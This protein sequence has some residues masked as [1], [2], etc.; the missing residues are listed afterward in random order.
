[1]ASIRVFLR[2]CFSSFF[3][4]GQTKAR[5]FIAQ[6]TMGKSSKK[7][8]KAASARRQNEEEEEEPVEDR[9]DASKPQFRHYDGGASEKGASSNNKVVL[10]ERFASVLTDPRFQLDVQDKYG[11]KKSKSSK[12]S[13]HQANEELSEFYT[14]EN[15]KDGAGDGAQQKASL[16]TKKQKGDKQDHED[17]DD[18]K[19][20]TSSSSSSS[21]DSKT[22]D[23]ERKKLPEETEEDPA[24]RIAYLTALSRGEIDVSSSSSSS[25]DDSDDDSESDNDNDSDDDSDAN[26]DPMLGKAGIL[27]PSTREEEEEQVELTTEESPYMAVQNMDWTNVRAVDI[28]TILSSFSP[29]GAVKRVQVFPSDFGKER[30]A[31]EA[32]FGPVG[33][34]KKNKKSQTTTSSDEDEDDDVKVAPHQSDDEREQQQDDDSIGADGS[35]DADDILIQVDNQYMPNDSGETDFDPEKLRAYE[36]SR[37]KYYFAVVEFASSQY[38]DIVYKEVDGMEFEH[39]SAAMDLR[40]IPVD[41]LA[42][43][44][45]NRE[46]RDEATNIPS[47][48]VPP[49]FVV[50]ALQQSNVQCTWDMGDRDRESTLTKYGS[51]QTWG[52]LA[53]GDDLKAYVASD[54][55]SDEESIEE[56]G[57]ASGMRKMLGLDSDD[58]K[59]NDTNDKDMNKKD[60][61]PSNESSSESESEDD[62]MEGT[63]QVTFVPGQLGLASKTGKMSEEN[64]EKTEALTPWEKFQE[65][66]KQKRREKRHV[67]REKRKEVN[68]MRKGKTKRGTASKPDDDFF[69]AEDSIENE[70]TGSDRFSA[71]QTKE[72]L[73]L[74]V[75]GE[76][77]DEAARDFDMRGLERLE[78]NKDKKLRGGRKRKE[79]K[80]AAN[81]TGTDFKVNIA[82]DRFNA[83]LDGS[84]DRFG[85]DRTDPNFKETGAMREILAEQTRRRKKKRKLVA[86]DSSKV[87]PDVSA[88]SATASTGSAALSALVSSIKSKVKR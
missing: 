52:E 50:N 75:A 60:D 37:L 53:E 30:L 81:V 62:G 36:A 20:S 2:S 83:L 19:K 35:N 29:P 51:G 88:D 43:V 87:A 46:L 21:N 11:R 23:D 82:D 56:N 7:K 24:S 67:A 40:T 1:M 41:A 12:K 27:D 44:V 45:R 15:G 57:K 79:E 69:M 78:K 10:D 16:A 22:S 64:E 17:D 72:E 5:I 74:L 39:S 80:Y 63:K 47:N 84:D 68:A 76:D 55:S 73:E 6:V 77:G 59:I 61:L 65:K 58:E 4:G 70:A 18:S 48:Y 9:F 38:A 26:E 8:Q 85:I 71:R 32:L 31:K 54:N 25:D 3:A 42:E 33:V 34:W 14:V 49:E 66:K 13:K 28:F 86:E